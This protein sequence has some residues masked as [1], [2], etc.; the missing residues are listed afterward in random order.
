MIGPPFNTRPGRP[1][2]PLCVVFTPPQFRHRETDLPPLQVVP[3][4]GKGSSFLND[5]KSLSGNV[6]TIFVEVTVIVF[7]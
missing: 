6:L 7:F 5:T 3:D 1:A 2:A 4:Q